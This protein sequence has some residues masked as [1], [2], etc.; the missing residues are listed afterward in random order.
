MARRMTFSPLISALLNRKWWVGRTINATPS[1]DE[2]RCSARWLV[3]N[4][5]CS[6][7]CVAA[8]FEIYSAT[9]RLSIR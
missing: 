7:K 8:H 6:F 5:I 3:E 1:P 9:V 2:E 4:I